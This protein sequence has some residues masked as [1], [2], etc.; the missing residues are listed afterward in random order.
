MHHV[1]AENAETL[2]TGLIASYGDQLRRFLLSRVRNASDVPDIAQ[3]VYLRML[4]VQNTASVRSPEAYLFTVAQHIVYQH[5]LGQAAL[6]P[7]A[8][9][10]DVLASQQSTSHL[11]PELEV[12]AHQCLEQLQNEL[13]TFGNGAWIVRKTPLTR[14]LALTV[15]QT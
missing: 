7:I 12:H 6:P 13:A 2:V 5:A 14:S 11:D 15:L 8:A 1:V 3:E 4:R 9:L 10:T